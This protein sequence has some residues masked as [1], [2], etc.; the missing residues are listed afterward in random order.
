MHP[1]SSSVSS[2]RG[3]GPNLI[4]SL[5]FLVD[6]VCLIL[7]ALVVKHLLDSLQFVFS[8]NCSICRYIFDVLMGVC[9]LCILLLC[10]LDLLFSPHFLFLQYPLLLNFEKLLGLKNSSQK[11]S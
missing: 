1:T 11:T 2:P 4:T 8:E 7:T 9:E 5:P 6:S 3:A 10:H